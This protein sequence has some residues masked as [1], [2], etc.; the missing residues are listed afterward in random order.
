MLSGV[1]PRNVITMGLVRS[2]L[3]IF[4][5]SVHHTIPRNRFLQVLISEAFETF[6]HSSI[7]NKAMF[8][9][10]KKQGVLVSK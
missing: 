5:L 7:L 10:S 6:C 1:G 2:L 8:C 9:L 3:S 4:C